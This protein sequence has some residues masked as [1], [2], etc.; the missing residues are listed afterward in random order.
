MQRGRR[1]LP[2]AQV[3][4]RGGLSAFLSESVVPGRFRQ[5]LDDAG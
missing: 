1:E 3:R 2:V 5:H 4:E